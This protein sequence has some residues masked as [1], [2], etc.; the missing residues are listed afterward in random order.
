MR[1]LLGRD[2]L[3]AGTGLWIVPCNSIHMFGMRFP[4]DAL[5]LDRGLVAVRLV[6][7]LLPGRLVWPVRRAHSVLE[8]PAGAL[9]RLG[10]REGTRFKWEVCES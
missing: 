5:F 2:G 6:E 7:Y 10:W 3:D 4:I 9:A 1:G 8:L